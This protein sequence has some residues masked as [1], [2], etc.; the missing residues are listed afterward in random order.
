MPIPLSAETSRKGSESEHF[1]KLHSPLNV[2]FY[3]QKRKCFTFFQSACAFAY[4]Y[5]QTI[6]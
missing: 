1:P 4:M 2:L 6:V 5:R 3:F